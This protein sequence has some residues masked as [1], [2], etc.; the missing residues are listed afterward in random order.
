MMRGD[1]FQNTRQRLCLD[2]VVLRDNLMVLAVDLRSYS[3]MCPTLSRG[4]ITQTPEC[5]PQV[6]SF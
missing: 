2:G 4:L 3:H 1:A 6:R 5:F